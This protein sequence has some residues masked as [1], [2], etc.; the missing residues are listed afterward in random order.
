MRCLLPQTSCKLKSGSK[1]IP[2]MNFCRL[3]QLILIAAVL[4]GCVTT[5]Y[6]AGSHSQDLMLYSTSREIALGRNL[7]ARIAEEEELP[8]SKNPY[9]LSRVEEIRKKI[10]DVVD[11][12]ALNYYVYVIEQDEMN[13][14]SIPGGHV[15][16]YEG[17]LN[18]LTDDELAFVIAHEIGHIVS[19]HAIK[20]MQAATGYHILLA[21][22]TQAPADPEFVRGLN[23][24]LGQIFVAYS[25]EDEY[26]ADELAVKYAEKAGFDPQAGIRALEKLKAAGKR[27]IR[28]I[29]YFRTHPYAQQRI[30]HIKEQLRL[31]LDVQDYMHQL[32]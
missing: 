32:R 12:T 18:E 16:I 23:F 14:F 9:Y 27:K 6:N 21:A 24:A 19:R 31:P 30:R 10:V 7:A 13:A 29:S 28:P 5:E 25:R 4:S 3:A 22:A 8:L 2:I 20:R 1:E 15:Y 26:N 11:R 17:L